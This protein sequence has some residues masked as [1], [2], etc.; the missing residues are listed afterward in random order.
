MNKKIAMVC[1]ALALL[2]Y[3]Q[4]QTEKKAD[5]L[6]K[7]ISVGL[8]GA[9]V[10]Q[11]GTLDIVTSVVPRTTGTNHFAGLNTFGHGITIDTGEARRPDCQ[12][13][14]RGTIWF[15]KNERKDSMQVCLREG[16]HYE[17][18]GMEMHAEP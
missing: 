17:W 7:C 15:T 4:A 8:S 13:A 16:G 1:G 14:L 9:L 10:C 5:A 12:E 3:G 6:D 2:V 11:Q 18:A